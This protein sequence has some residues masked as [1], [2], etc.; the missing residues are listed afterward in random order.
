ML[1]VKHDRQDNDS[2]IHYVTP[3]F[4]KFVYINMYLFEAQFDVNIL[5]IPNVMTSQEELPV[6]LLLGLFRLSFT[7]EGSVIFT[8]FFSGRCHVS[9][10][11][12]RKDVFIN[13]TEV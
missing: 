7:L 4:A 9:L 1:I 3:Y 2:P 6:M 12:T 8:I 11:S 13:K 5:S 10:G